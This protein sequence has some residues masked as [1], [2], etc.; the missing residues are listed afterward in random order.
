VATPSAIAAVS[1][2]RREAAR[3][4]VVMKVLLKVESVIGIALS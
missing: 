1:K 3:R 4:W 2:E